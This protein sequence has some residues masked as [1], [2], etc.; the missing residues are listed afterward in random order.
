MHDAGGVR[1]TLHPAP[2]TLFFHHEA[3]EG[4]S[5]KCTKKKMGSVLNLQDYF[6]KR[7]AL[8]LLKVEH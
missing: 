2:C 4:K 8:H 7:D 3:H 1:E 5:A 6:P